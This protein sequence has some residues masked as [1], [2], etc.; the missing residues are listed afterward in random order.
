[1]LGRRPSFV[2]SPLGSL[3][4]ILPGEPP[5]VFEDRGGLVQVR[6]A[7]PG[8]FEKRRRTS[9]SCSWLLRSRMI[10]PDLPFLPV[11][12]ARFPQTTMLRRGDMF[13][14]SVSGAR[15][16][17]NVRAVTKWVAWPQAKLRTLVFVKAAQAPTAGRNIALQFL[18]RAHKHKPQSPQFRCQYVLILLRKSMTIRFCCRVKRVRVR[19]T[20]KRT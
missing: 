18:K 1:M 19:C 3:R 7:P 5:V 17:R 16:H 20:T 15:H 13:E 9:L 12:P 10:L 2:H 4:R 11:L 6:V 8:P 14:P